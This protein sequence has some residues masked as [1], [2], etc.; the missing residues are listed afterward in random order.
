MSRACRPRGSGPS[1]R[2]RPRRRQPGGGNAYVFIFARVRPGFGF[3]M[4]RRI[5]AKGMR[6]MLPAALVLGAVS[7][8]YAADDVKLPAPFATPSVRNTPRVIPQ[9]AGAKL[10]VP[11]GFSMEIWAEGFKTPRFM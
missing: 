6:W 1:R 9:P 3:R 10:N 4:L 11:A 5:Y 2:C 8:F 7:L